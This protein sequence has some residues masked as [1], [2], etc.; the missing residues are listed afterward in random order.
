LDEVRYP[1][2]DSDN[3]PASFAEVDVKLNDNDAEFDTVMVAGSVGTK[4]SDE[5]KEVVSLMAGWWIYIKS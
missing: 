4:V 5:R 2:L 1:S 3:V